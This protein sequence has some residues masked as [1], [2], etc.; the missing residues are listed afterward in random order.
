M[1]T[2]TKPAVR[3]DVVRGGGGRRPPIKHAEDP[4]FP[5]KALCG[6]RLGRSP[7]SASGD[8]CAVCRDLARRNFVGR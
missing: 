3:T 5:G 4:R 7:S 1:K 2:A 6:A 8:R